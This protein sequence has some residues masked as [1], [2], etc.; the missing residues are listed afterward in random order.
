[1]AGAGA[2]RLEEYPDLLTDQDLSEIYGIARRT[3]RHKRLT[4]TWGPRR[5]PNL[6]EAKTPKAEVIRDIAEVGADLVR[7]LGLRPRRSPIRRA[8]LPKAG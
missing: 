5:L 8:G 2:K 1:M 7:R 3:I 6:H 4:G